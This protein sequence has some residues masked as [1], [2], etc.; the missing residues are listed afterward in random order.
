MKEIDIKKYPK[1][2]AKFWSK[3]DMLRFFECWDWMGAKHNGG[4]GSFRFN[5]KCFYAHRISFEFLK[6][7]IPEKMVID[8]ICRNRLCVNP[9]HLRVVTHREN[10]IY[11]SNSATAKNKSKT[12]CK[13][14]HEFNEENSYKTLRNGNPVRQCKICITNKN[15]KAISGVCLLCKR[16]YAA[17]RQ[18]AKREHRRVDCYA[19]DKD[20]KINIHES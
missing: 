20:K 18:H 2:T 15:K 13:R 11:N 17:V 1:A 4:Y 10:T 14:G 12:H 3:V 5:G 19:L 6:H 8:H 9:S 16:H 7:K